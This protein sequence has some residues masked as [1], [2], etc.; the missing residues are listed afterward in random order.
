MQLI[1]G[2]VEVRMAKKVGSGEWLSAAHLVEG[3]DD[4]QGRGLQMKLDCLRA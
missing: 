3:L 1:D 4:F 2:G